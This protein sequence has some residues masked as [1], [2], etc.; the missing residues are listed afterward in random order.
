MSH[1][2]V[3]MQKPISEYAVYL[4]NLIPANI[5][6]SYAL[7]PIFEDVANDE[8]IRKGVV[9]FRDFLYILC[10]RL[11]SN[12][13]LYVKLKKT[14]DPNDYPFLH[15]ITN[16]LV[17]IGYYG[18]L[19][20]NG[21]SILISE[22]PVCTAP[23]ARISGPATMECLRFLA[24]CGFDF[25]GIDLNAK[26]PD[27]SVNPFEV[28]YPAN[29]LLLV[30]LKA[31]SIADIKLR[32]SRRYWNDL[33]LLGCHYRL[34]QVDPPDMLGI[35]KDY[36]HPLSDGLKQFALEIYERYTD[37]GM[38][39][40]TIR[41]ADVFFSFANIKNKNRNL[42]SQEIYEK[43]TFEFAISMKHGF[44]LMVRSKKT[45]RYADIIAAFP[46]YLKDKIA[47]G[48][49]CDRKLR[50]EPCQGGCQG[51]RIPFDES[52]LTMK[53]DIITWLDQEV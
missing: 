38:I 40:A 18:N 44:C 36:I 21:E 37:K 32:E 6:E 27:L 39:P 19:S 4:R 3:E 1:G 15:N 35:L 46:K 14:R 20:E 31:L 52:I 33:F 28:T 5:P 50:N 17:D 53:Q 42:S 7:K 45:D 26:L 49:G 2:E 13:H 29:P 24:I 11:I 47:Q 8:D 25:A 12:G 48:Y 43:R 22:I 9:A 23:K 51:I 30:G 10:D 34:L 41:R 16:L